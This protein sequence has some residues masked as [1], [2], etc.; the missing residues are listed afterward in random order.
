M[1][2][3]FKKSKKL[4]KQ[5]RG[6]TVLIAALV[7]SI[8][9][10]IGLSIFNTTVKDLFFASSA[11]ESLVAFYAADAAAECA[12]FWDY[13]RATV[14]NTFAT[15]TESVEGTTIWD[16]TSLAQPRACAGQS[17][18]TGWATSGVTANGAQTT[19]TLSVPIASG[20]TTATVTV[21]K[22][23]NMGTTIT[24]INALGYNNASLANPRTVQRGVQFS[25]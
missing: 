19:F 8:L 4:L 22:Q 23:T 24:T 2:K 18:A 12:Q 25:Y 5:K 7:S 15:S 16:H 21:S 9:L 6:I 1:M 14:L 20:F 17:I 11:K 3:F 10:A 13:P